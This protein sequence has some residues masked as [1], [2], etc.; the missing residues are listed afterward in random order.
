MAGISV[1]LHPPLTPLPL[2]PSFHFQPHPLSL[3]S[4]TPPCF[5][6]AAP[7][8]C[9]EH[10]CTSTHR[11]LLL[12]SYTAKNHSLSEAYFAI[13]THWTVKSAC[14]CKLQSACTHAAS[15]NR[16]QDFTAKRGVQC[17]PL[18]PP[19]GA[20]VTTSLQ[21]MPR[22]PCCPQGE[23]PEDRTRGNP[24]RTG[25]QE[26]EVVLCFQVGHILWNI[27]APST[28]PEHKPGRHRVSRAHGEKEHLSKCLK[29]TFREGN[30]WPSSKIPQTV[31]LL[32]CRLRDCL[33]V[34]YRWHFN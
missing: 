24:Q 19:R 15:W 18:S 10:P 33:S 4:P 31:D 34:I 30:G 21:S 25:C 8:A 29:A 20:S 11:E 5:V 14:D 1:L 7:M 22:I 13:R 16:A 2:F 26:E 17:L 23:L 28:I 3:R 12:P 9:L 32:H 27:Q 6:R